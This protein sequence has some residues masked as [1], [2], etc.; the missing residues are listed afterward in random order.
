MSHAFAIGYDWLHGALTAEEQATVREALIEK[1][2]HPAAEAYAARAWWAADSFNWNNVCNGGIA[3]A[4][5][6]LADEE[7]DLCRPLLARAL[8]GLPRALA[9]YAP[10]GA[11][12]EGPGYWGYATK[13]HRSDTGGAPERPGLR[14]RT[15]HPPRPEPDRPLP[16]PQRRPGGTLL[17]LRRRRRARRG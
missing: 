15:E 12:S 3:I 7:P 10:D 13:L 11:W 9:S 8:K 14:L 6:A 1:G 4:A 17:Q 5:L 16:A 2:L